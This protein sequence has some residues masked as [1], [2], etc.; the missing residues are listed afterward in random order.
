ML[1]NPDYLKQLQ[2]TQ[3][4]INSL[5]AEAYNAYKTKDYVTVFA[6]SNEAFSVSSQNDLASKFLF[7][8]AL[9]TGE[10]GDINGMKQILDKI[11][12][13]F[14]KDEITPRA[15]DILSVI[16]SGKYDPDLYKFDEN[17]DYNYLMVIL[18]D[19]DKINQIKMKLIAFNVE[20]YADRDLKIEEKPF[21]DQHT[22][23]TVKSMKGKID[24]IKYFNE[25]SNSLFLKEMDTKIYQHFII[26]TDNYIKLQKLA[27]T[28]KYLEF[29]KNKLML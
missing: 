3:D 17:A 20:K 8:N 5:Y 27:D 13:D 9:S 2:D 10:S 29:F 22:Q 21:D 4:K 23:I 26:S 28:S 11:V 15:I 14:P 25:I 6:K 24:G 18:N 16:N 19:K 12:L 1:V 7:L